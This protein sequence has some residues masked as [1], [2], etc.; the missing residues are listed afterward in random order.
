MRVADAEQAL[1]A[2]DAHTLARLGSDNPALGPMSAIL[3]RTE[4]ASSTQIEDLTV[5]ARQLALAWRVLPMPV[6]QPIVNAA[7]LRGRLDVPAMSAQRALAQ[8][9]D[10]GVLQE[11]TARSRNRVWHHRGILAILDDYAAKVRRSG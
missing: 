7:H 2:L 11:T 3:L 5:G 10:T 6:G 1:A 4:S 8:L 9:T